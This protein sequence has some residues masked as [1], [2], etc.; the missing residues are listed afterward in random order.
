MPGVSSWTSAAGRLLTS[1]TL[2]ASDTL[3]KSADICSL[4]E[5]IPNGVGTS[6]SVLAENIMGASVVAYTALD[7]PSFCRASPYVL[8]NCLPVPRDL[9]P[10]GDR[11]HLISC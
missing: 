1:G 4:G 6:I 10:E 11:A 9:Q 7:I 8:A 2:A 5:S 3:C